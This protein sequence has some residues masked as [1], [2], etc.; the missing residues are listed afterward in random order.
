MA[1][2]VNIAGV[3][4]SDVPSVTLKTPQS[5]DVIF[6]DAKSLNFELDS[7]DNIMPL[8]SDGFVYG[9][10]GGGITAKAILMAQ[11]TYNDVPAIKLPTSSDDAWFIES[12]VLK[13]GLDSNGD[14]QPLAANETTTDE[15]FEL[16]SNGDLIPIS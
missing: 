1:Q 2:T 16:D 3:T 10:S 7:N 8:T 6:L 9:T 12:S 4:Y 15:V 14:I 5:S 11:V 13:F